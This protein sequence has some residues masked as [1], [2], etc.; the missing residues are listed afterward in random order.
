MSMGISLRKHLLKVP[1][2][3]TRYARGLWE[4]FGTTDAD[5]RR[6]AI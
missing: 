2:Q 1:P 4:A 5:R 6:S 3:R